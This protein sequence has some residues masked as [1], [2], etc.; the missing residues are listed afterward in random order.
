M[1]CIIIS[2]GDEL[3]IGQTINTNAGWMGSELNKIGVEVTEVLTISDQGQAINEALT[4]AETRAG[5]VL[6]TGGLGPTKDDITKKVF[7]D[8]FNAPLVEN[9]QALENA[10][11]FFKRYN[12]PML[13]VNKLQALVPEGCQ[14]LLNKVGTAPGMWMENRNAVFVSMPGVPSE[15]RYL[16]QNEVLSRIKGQFKL[17]VIVHKT[18]MTLGLGESYIAEEIKD[19]EDAI[20]SYIKL[21]YLPSPGLVKL[22]LSGKGEDKK[23]LE[24]EIEALFDRIE[25]RIPESVYAR[26]E[27]MIE[28][29]VGDKLRDKGYTIA[30]AESC[31]SGAL[32][33]KIASVSGASEY[34]IGSIVAYSNDVKKNILDVN[35]EVLM[36]AGAV[37][38]E[39]VK[40][41]ALGAKKLFGTDYAI[42]TSGIAGPTGGTDEKPIGTVWIGIAF[43]QGVITEKFQMGK[44]RERVVRKTVLVALGRILSLI[45]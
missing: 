16:M 28:E 5:I 11:G 31:T 25:E 24:I 19:I 20:P 4:Y 45:K 8:F 43:P 38:Q 39:T 3:L 33:S 1:N 27:V 41:M 9:K 34:F 2:V 15:M 21:A 12:R 32:A 13:P 29:I 22:R 36:S 35:E 10:E 40:Q 23:I 37:S 7:A 6:L 30:T 18:I 17:P 14:M 44:V 26:K 42:A